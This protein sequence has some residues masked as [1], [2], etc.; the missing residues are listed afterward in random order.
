MRREGVE[1]EFGG[2]GWRE[3]LEGWFGGR[4]WRD[5]MEGGCAEGFRM[6][7]WREGWRKS[8]EGGCGGRVWREGVEVHRERLILPWSVM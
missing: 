4:V 8:L 3:G 6:M 5:V 2:R 1:G 7:V